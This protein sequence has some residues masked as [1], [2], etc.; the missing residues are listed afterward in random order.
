MNS[1]GAPASNTVTYIKGLILS[2]WASL[3]IISMYT[4]QAILRA[5]RKAR[6]SGSNA[7]LMELFL[8]IRCCVGQQFDGLGVSSLQMAAVGW[9]R[10]CPIVVFE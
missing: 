2:Q 5:G 6:G 1:W 7:V 4:S 3:V 9:S 10:V 8:F